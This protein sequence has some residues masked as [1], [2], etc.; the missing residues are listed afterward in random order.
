MKGTIN[1][2]LNENMNEKSIVYE[3]IKRYT[4]K[5][6][7]NIV[8]SGAGNIND[9]FF[10]SADSGKYVLQRLQKKM[11][12]A[13]L[14]YNFSLYSGICE[15]EKLLYPKWIKTEDGSFFASDST[16]NNWRMY[17]YIEGD[18]LNAPLSEE[19]CYACGEGLGRIH[20]ALRN[21]SEAPRPVYPHLH[22][23]EYYFEQYEKALSEEGTCAEN[24]DPEIEESIRRK[25]KEYSS[26]EADDIAVIHGDAKA[27]NILFRDGSV[28]GFLDW[29]TV[30]TGSVCEEV[31]D[32]IRSACI[33]D[34]V[35]NTATANALIEG[36]RAGARA[37]E[38][39]TGRIPR[40]FDKICF[41][42]G[43]RYYT[44]AISNNKH[45][46]EK[47]PGYRLKRAKELF[48]SR[49]PES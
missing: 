31:A 19:Q 4:K 43:L 10:V 37:D 40:A 17:P 2:L 38:S 34:G 24:R 6:I 22:D 29:D 28:C 26:L 1:N 8:R 45:F 13:K 35:M 46:K 7:L 48:C 18:I 42:L 47:Y 11:D 14:E 30:M 3:V 12:T 15:K 49:W 25:M 23:P 21:M 39:I 27:S 5:D 20:A 9:T 41:E 16:G 44:D 36:Y 32:C 33:T